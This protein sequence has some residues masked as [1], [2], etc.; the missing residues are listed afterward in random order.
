M[1]LQINIDG[2]QYEADI[3]VLE[4]ERH[5]SAALAQARSATKRTSHG[6]GP[7]E[8]ALVPAAGVSNDKACKS[9]IVGIVVTVLV[10]VGEDVAA[11]QPL[12]VLEAMKMESN[13]VSPVA[14]RIKAVCVAAGE[15]VKKGQVLIEF[16]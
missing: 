12:L 14:G 10:K 1:K 3:E 2:K 6:M 5:E 7:I 4:E 16:E 11:G 9:T 13:I 8:S 15:S